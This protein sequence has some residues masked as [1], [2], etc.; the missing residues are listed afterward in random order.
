MYYC[1][2]K[3]I[4][5][6]DNT[7]TTRQGKQATP[8]SLKLFRQTI[9]CSMS[10]SKP[11]GSSIYKDPIS[12]VLSALQFTLGSSRT[13]YIYGGAVRDY[14]RG[15]H[16]SD[17]DVYI[18]RQCKE[19]PKEASCRTCKDEVQ[20]IKFFAVANMLRK[21][22]YSCERD[23]HYSLV[24]LEVE[25]NGKK[26]AIDI[27]LQEPT[28][29]DF[30]CNNLM[31]LPSGDIQNRF[32]APKEFED[33]DRTM[34]LLD[35]IRDAIGGKLVWMIPR[36]VDNQYRYQ[37]PDVAYHNF[38]KALKSRYEHMVAKGFDPRTTTNGFILKQRVKYDWEKDELCPVCHISSEKNQETVQLECGHGY[39]VHCIDEWVKTQDRMDTIDQLRTCPQ[40]R[41]AIVYK[42]KPVD[43]L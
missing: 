13:A 27:S 14:L 30:T 20:F 40:C 9:L 7:S 33:E 38:H 22:D 15:E 6:K 26:V 10:L 34:W 21:A 42:Y 25:I 17:I 39:H 18:S 41:R 12:I 2:P 19:H 4:S 31:M 3:S 23:G 37:K 29:C 11:Y 8:A 36:H 5:T 43:C 35:G 1:S 28:H 32:P 24:K 16:F